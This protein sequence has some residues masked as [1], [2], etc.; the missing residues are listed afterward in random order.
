MT[1]P[2]HIGRATVFVRDHAPVRAERYMLDGDHR[3][4]DHG[5]LEIALV[6]GGSGL[7]R[8]LH[9]D[10]AL[11]RGDAV[12]LRPG[13]WHA[14]LDCV[15][16]E[17]FNC[18]VGEEV[19]RRELAW[20][21]EDPLLGRL[22]SMLPRSLDREGAV[23]ATL[24][25]TALRDCLAWLE[26]LEV[27]SAPD[28]PPE[29]AELFAFLLLVLGRIA[30]QVAVAPRP[31]TSAPVPESVLACIG[32][33]EDDPAR[34]WTLADFAQHTRLNASHVSRLFTRATGLPPMAYLGRWRLER[35][36]ALLA[37][38]DRPVAEIG[39]EVGWLDANLFARRFRTHFGMSATAY[40]AQWTMGST[41]EV[42]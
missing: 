17:V 35:A 20:M 12:V 34:A 32:L 30:R 31:P 21:L 10:R 4:H 23:T 22:F 36:A 7:H 19:L 26:Q 29:R 25:V 5:F 11:R 33:M 14:Y 1:L 41:L 39:A 16:L 40:R 24:D 2:D 6:T 28:R 8:T 9:G 38:T 37:Q 3:Q 15:A 42:T 27:L 18:Y 13:V